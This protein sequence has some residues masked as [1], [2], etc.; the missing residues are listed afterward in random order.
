LEV[1]KPIPGSFD[2]ACTAELGIEPVTAPAFKF[3]FAFAA[4]TDSEFLIKT[5]STFL[6]CTQPATA[7]EISI[8]LLLSCLLF[9]GTS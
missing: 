4:I 7:F 3:T 1:A 8:G 2:S 6:L 5:L 9:D